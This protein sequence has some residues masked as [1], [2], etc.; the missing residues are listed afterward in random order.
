MKNKIARVCLAGLLL[1]VL[2]GPARNMPTHA[3]PGMRAQ[4]DQ[5]G[6][7]VIFGNT[8]GHDCATGTPAPVVGSVGACGL[9]T[10]D[11]APDVY[12]RSAS[13]SSGQAQADNTI[14]MAQARSTAVLMLPA[15][16]AVTHAYLYWAATLSLSGSDTQVTLERPGSFSAQVTTLEATTSA[17]NSYRSMLNER[18]SPL[19]RP[20]RI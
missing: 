13:P 18:V 4:V 9:N 6:S 3:A 10:V 2:A 14:S 12:W 19:A 1:L 11:T 20:P 16:A 5:H 17:N 15:G 8:L 7:F